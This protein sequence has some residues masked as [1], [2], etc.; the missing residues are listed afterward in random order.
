MGDTDLRQE[1]NMNPKERELIQKVIKHARKQRNASTNNEDFDY[2]HG[3]LE[4]KLN[5]L[6][7]GE[8]RCATK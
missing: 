8:T 2:W 7:T 5:E 4:Q 3:I 1:I 6:K